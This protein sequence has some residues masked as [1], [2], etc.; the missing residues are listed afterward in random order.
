MMQQIFLFSNN[1]LP[2]IKFAY[3]V[4]DWTTGVSF[5][6]GKTEFCLGQG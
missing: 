1:T 5:G 3:Q 2:G 6:H 4:C